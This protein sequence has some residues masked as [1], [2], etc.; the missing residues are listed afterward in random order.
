MRAFVAETHI[1]L[2]QLV[3]P[4]F[5]EEEIDAPIPI[6]VMP[7]VNRIPEKQLSSR[8]RELEALDL[9]AVILFGVSHHKDEVGSD[10]WDPQ[11][12]IA[13]SLRICKET[14]PN[15][16]A[17]ADVCFCEYTT[18]GHCGVLHETVVENDKTIENLAK[19]AVNFARAGADIIAPSAMM[20]GQVAAIRKA[21]DG[22]SFHS[23]PI[24]AY[25]SK[26][27]SCYYG[28]F[29][30]AAG[31]GVKGD[32]KTYQMPTGN[33]REAM[34]E[35][36]VDVAEGADILLIKPAQPC[37]DIIHAVRERTTVPIAAYQVSGEYS[38][39]KFAAAANAINETDAMWESLTAIKRAGADIIITYFAEA[40]AL[41]LKKK[42]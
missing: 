41:E 22:A 19:Q 20:D 14:C 10:T 30:D 17:I 33:F 23:V 5:I 29:R 1:D 3:Y 8:L 35:S 36:L 31:S 32:R 34:Q 2:R 13:R 39:I 18:H 28:P 6:P 27:A 37:L 26:H 16:L 38:C 11:G 21:L 15:M 25:S 24:M 12:L 40:L 9:N 42:V 4:L 7:G